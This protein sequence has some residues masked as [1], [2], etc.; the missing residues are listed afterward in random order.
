MLNGLMMD[1]SQLSL[2]A[3]VERAE[4]LTPSSAVVSRLGDGSMRRM[5]F[6]ECAER[7]RRLAA[8]IAELGIGDGDRVAHAAVE[9]DRA[10]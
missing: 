4:R 8:G 5:T 2:T 7:A 3:L 9:P 1:D 6:G 10:P